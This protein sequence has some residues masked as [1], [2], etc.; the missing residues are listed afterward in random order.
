[1]KRALF[2]V[3]FFYAR[4]CYALLETGA[5]FLKFSL[6]SR[7]VGT[8]EAQ[9]AAVQ[10]AFGFLYNPAG[11]TDSKK[12]FLFSYSQ[13]PTRD[14][15]LG[16]VGGIWSY[17]KFAN[18]ALG[19]LNYRTEPIPVTGESPEIIGEAV[20]SD[21]AFCFGFGKKLISNF[22]VGLNLKYIYRYEKDP[23]YGKAIGSALCLDSGIVYSIRNFRFGLSSLNFGT[24]VKYSNDPKEDSLPESFRSG[25]LWNF[26]NEKSKKL[27]L[28]SDFV[29]D[30]GDK[31]RPHIGLELSYIET[32][33]IRFGYFSKE[34]NIEG[35]NYGL[36]FIYKGFCFGWADQEA[37][38]LGSGRTSVVSLSKIF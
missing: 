31:F 20:W 19:L 29:K 1:M 38:K 25:I 23:V 27:D 24:K 9:T 35:V 32:V 34:G 36:G 10:D 15:Y 26:Y 21:Y 7:A 17:K 5:D 3:L 30:K 12:E 11:L 14:A 2:F 28:Y 4:F 18:F 16:Y 22:F 8:G 37:G 6:S 13:P 33:Y